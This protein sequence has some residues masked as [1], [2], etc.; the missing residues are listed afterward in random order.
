MIILAFY[1]FLVDKRKCLCI[2][3]F[4]NLSTYSVPYFLFSLT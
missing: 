1:C 3:C 2:L 4:R